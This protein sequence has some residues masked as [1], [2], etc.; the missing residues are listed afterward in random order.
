M[1]IRAGTPQQSTVTIRSSVP[2]L[3]LF[4]MPNE[5][6]ICLEPQSHPVDAHNMEGQPG[7]VLLG[8][9]E[10]MELVMGIEV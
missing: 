10:N 8:K 2:Y 7:L 5:P 6:F 9:G 1:A 3:M 4:Q